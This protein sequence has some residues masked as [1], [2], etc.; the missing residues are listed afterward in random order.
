MPYE[1][2]E[3]DADKCDEI[4]DSGYDVVN[5][6]THEVKD[7]HDEKPDADRQ[8]RILSELKKDGEE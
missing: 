4:A 5:E 6:L 7:H 8:V 1:V 3:H 2:H